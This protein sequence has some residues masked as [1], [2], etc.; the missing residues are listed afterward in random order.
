MMFSEYLRERAWADKASN[1]I[2]KSNGRWLR[3]FWGLRTKTIATFLVPALLTVGLFAWFARFRLR[4][5]L[6]AE[7]GHRLISIARSATTLLP[8][9]L[10]HT[11]Q[12]GDRTSRTYR[13]LKRRLQGLQQATGVRRIYVF[14]RE[15]RSLLDTDPQIPIGTRYVNLSFDEHELRAVFAGKPRAS[16]LFQDEQGKQYKTGFAPLS[17]DNEV[18]AVIAVDGSAHYFQNLRN[19]QRELF[20]YGLL[21]IA[22]VVFTGI[23]FA[24]WLLSPVRKLVYAARKM[25]TGE[26]TEEIPSLRRDEIGFL[27]KTMEEM[28]QNILARDRQM[29]MMLSGIAHEVRNPLGGMELFSG[30]L[31]EELAGDEVKI[32]HIDRI[33]RELRYLA[34]VVN[35]F[36][37]YARP[38]TIQKELH[39]WQGFIFEIAMLLSANAEPKA[40]SLNIVGEDIPHGISFDRARM[41]QVILNVVQNAIQASPPNS[42]ISLQSELQTDCLLFSVRDCGSG[43]PEEQRQRVFEPFYTREKGTGLG[44]PLAKKFV[45]AHSGMLSIECPPEGGTIVKI[46]LPID[47]KL[48]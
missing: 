20:V 37:D 3:P 25:G 46:C 14:D 34:D 12:P 35:S 36:L 28:R 8:P 22:L 2:T 42:A 21:S 24:G 15:R 10:L 16:L 39:N 19:M 26:L 9:D 30:I 44:L 6:D 41:Q 7:L 23:V 4:E 32:S 5:G 1:V 27:A 18:I 47:K 48:K 38:I 29:Q 43:I 17:D 11:L 40:I 33:Q 31:R 13:N 45:E